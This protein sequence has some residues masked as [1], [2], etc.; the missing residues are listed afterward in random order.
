ME[1]DPQWRD[2]AFCASG[3]VDPMFWLG[4]QTD[5]Y[6]LA[7]HFCRSHCPVYAFCRADAMARPYR[8]VVAGGIVWSDED[9]SRPRRSF[10]RRFICEKCR[11]AVARL[12]S[13]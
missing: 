8:G 10:R 3:E 6:A 9:R 4:E 1:I 7:V 2:K 13:G 11:E 5:Y 12:M